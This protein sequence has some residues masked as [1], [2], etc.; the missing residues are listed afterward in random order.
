MGYVKLTH[1]E[2]G[3]LQIVFT[4]CLFLTGLQFGAS[5]LLPNMFQADILDN[6]ELNTKKRF[7]ASL[8][9][10]IRV[11]ST[12]SGTIANIA[13]PLILYGSN[14]I[15]GYQQG[16][17]DGTAQTL[18]TK[19][20]LLFFYAVMHGIMMFLAGVPFFFYK[21]TRAERERVHNAALAQREEFEK[22]AAENC[23]AQN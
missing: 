22:N 1:E 16:L 7:D 14:S 13:A 6:L 17:A 2:M 19:I 20:M 18:Q 10:V 3:W 23:A 15:I 11:G 21:L 5:N 4:V 8:P 12:V 9:F